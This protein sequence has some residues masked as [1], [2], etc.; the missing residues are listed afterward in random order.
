MSERKM[1]VWFA[2]LPLRCPIR[3]VKPL[4]ARPEFS[5]GVRPV[6]RSYHLETSDS[7]WFPCTEFAAHTL[8]GSRMKANRLIPAVAVLALAVGPVVPIGS[9][10]SVS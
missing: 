2:V 10:E 8:G 6:S 5:P 9:E 4:R 7:K 1:R 3:H